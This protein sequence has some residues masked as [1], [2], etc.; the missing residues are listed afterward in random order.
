MKHIKLFEDYT[1]EEIGDLI[2]DLS[3]VGLSESPLKIG[4]RYGNKV[5]RLNPAMLYP[6]I[7][8]LG[9]ILGM[10]PE[11]IKKFKGKK[12]VGGLLVAIAKEMKG[13][14]TLQG[15]PIDILD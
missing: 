12:E 11:E 2:D 10:S 5:H 4:S 13:Y 3:S 15:S 1:E 6:V 9:K 14:G 7:G 8:K